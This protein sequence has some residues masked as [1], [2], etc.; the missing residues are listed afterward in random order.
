MLELTLCMSIK[1]CSI[2]GYCNLVIENHG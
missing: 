2:T 1:Q